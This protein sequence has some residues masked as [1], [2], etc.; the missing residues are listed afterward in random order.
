MLTTKLSSRG[1]LVIPKQLRDAHHWS[2]DTEFIVQDY[3]NGILLMPVTAVKKSRPLSALIGALP[4]PR[5][6]VSHGAL[7][8]PVSDYVE[9]TS[10]SQ[11]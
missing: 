9:T 6:A 5:R 2:T 8:A 4:A 11:P 1:Q 3:A 10:R 7:V